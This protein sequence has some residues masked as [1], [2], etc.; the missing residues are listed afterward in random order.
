MEF[1]RCPGCPGFYAHLYVFFSILVLITIFF[2]L[3]EILSKKRNNLD[4]LDTTAYLTELIVF[5]ASRSEHLGG[6]NPDIMDLAFIA[7]SAELH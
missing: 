3:S 5:S 4:I 7:A 6:S 1:H 2:I